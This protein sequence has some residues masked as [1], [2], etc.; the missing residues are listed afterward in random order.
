[1]WEVSVSAEA[2]EKP[3]S[4]SGVSA[5]VVALKQAVPGQA[6]PRGGLSASP[7]AKSRVCFLPAGQIADRWGW[8]DS[9]VR[10]L[11]PGSCCKPKAVV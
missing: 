11:D 1:L 9:L 10:A 5:A 7:E 3:P 8:E 4:A 6:V 2:V